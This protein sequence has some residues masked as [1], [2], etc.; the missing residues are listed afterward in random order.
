MLV[1]ARVDTTTYADR[2]CRRCRPRG[3]WRCGRGQ[4]HAQIDKLTSAIIG[5]EAIV[6][7]NA[8]SASVIGGV[9]TGDFSGQW[10]AGTR[11]DPRRGYSGAIIRRRSSRRI[12]QHR[13]RHLCRYRRRAVSVELIDSGTI[14]LVGNGVAINSKTPSAGSG[15]S[16]TVSA[17]AIRWMSLLAL[18]VRSVPAGWWHRWFVRCRSHPQ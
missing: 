17:R 6:D 14:A 8:L 10:L 11:V 4:R 7:A 1:G 9:P 3:W 15:Q 16:V 13:C 5:G 2:R 12:G 18:P